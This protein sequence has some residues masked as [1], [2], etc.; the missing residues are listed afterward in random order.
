MAQGQ[1]RTIVYGASAADRLGRSVAVG[2]LGGDGKAELL[3]GA[4]GGAGVG[5]A[6]PDSGELYVISTSSRPGDFAR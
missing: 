6:L 1:A 3:L 2:D 5:S 4:P